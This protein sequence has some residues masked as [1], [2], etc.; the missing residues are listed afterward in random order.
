MDLTGGGARPDDLRQALN[1]GL[2]KPLSSLREFK[3]VPEE[4]WGIRPMPMRP[5]DPKSRFPKAISE[6]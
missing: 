1:S 5:P 3:Q 2:T 6:H 4:S